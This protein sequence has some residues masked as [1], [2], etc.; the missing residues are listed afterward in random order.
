MAQQ[1]EGV[2]ERRLPTTAEWIGKGPGTQS[3][4]LMKVTPST[5]AGETR[6]VATAPRTVAEVNTATRRITI[7]S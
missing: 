7:Y 1:L 4:Q 5:A 2:P 3:D 6:R